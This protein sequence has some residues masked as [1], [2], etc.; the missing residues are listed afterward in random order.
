MPDRANIRSRAT[1][2]RWRTAAVD[3]PRSP[4]LASV[5]LGNAGI[6]IDISKRSN[7]GP[8]SRLK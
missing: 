6:S 3:S 2:T 8:E 7:K 1:H 5:P 4:P